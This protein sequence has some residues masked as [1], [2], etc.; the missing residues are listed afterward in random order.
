MKC[1][2]KINSSVPLSRCDASG[3]LSIPDTFGACQDIAAQHAELI[4]VGGKAMM[5]RGLFWLTPLT[6]T[7]DH[8]W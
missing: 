3:R 6:R 4:G 5:S 7:S 8:A 1:Y 2:L